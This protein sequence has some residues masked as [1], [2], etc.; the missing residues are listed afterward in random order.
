[1]WEAFATAFRAGLEGAIAGALD[2]ALL[3]P[4]PFRRTAAPFAAAIAAGL[5]VGIGGALA[6]GARGLAP[7]DVAAL[8]R[9]GEHL[10]ALALVALTLAARGRSAGTSPQGGRK[11]VEIV[12]GRS[13]SCSCPVRSSPRAWRTSRSCA[14]AA[15][16]VAAGRVRPP[17]RASAP[18]PRGLEPRGRGRP[19]PGGGGPLTPAS[20]SRDRVSPST[21]RSPL[22]SPAWHPARHALHLVSSCSGAGPRSSRTSG[23]SSVPTRGARARRCRVAPSAAWRLRGP[24][25]PPADPTRSRMHRRLATPAR[26]L[27]GVPCAPRRARVV[28]IWTAR[29]GGD[30][31][32][33]R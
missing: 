25:R 11:L 10:Y 3:R 19:R 21:H 18:L 28:A 22:P 32:T 31:C 17:R 5:L 33:T 30:G 16:P 6:L 7:G 4:S 23:S 1:M 24:S 2:E 13:S 14:C 9:R 15:P 27:G 29:A 26:R 20:S 12:I 8:V